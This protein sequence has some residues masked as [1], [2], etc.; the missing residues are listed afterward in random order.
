MYYVVTLTRKFFF[1]VVFVVCLVVL[2]VVA[3]VAVVVPLASGAGSRKE[4]LGYSLG[5]A[6][7]FRWGGFLLPPV[8][9]LT[10]VLFS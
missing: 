8:V 7:P 3:V 2:F 10:G 5:L 9:V 1:V 4:K 6:S